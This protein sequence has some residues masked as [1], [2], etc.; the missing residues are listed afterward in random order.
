MKGAKKPVRKTS[1]KIF[2]TLGI[3]NKKVLSEKFLTTIC[4]K[5]KVP[6]KTLPREQIKPYLKCPTKRSPWIFIL[7]NHSPHNNKPGIWVKLL[8]TVIE[9]KIR[10]K[11]N[12]KIS[13]F[14][15]PLSIDH[16]SNQNKGQYGWIP[17]NP[18]QFGCHKKITG[19]KI[20]NTIDNLFLKNLYIQFY[21]KICTQSITWGFAKSNTLAIL[22]AWNG[23]SRDLTIPIGIFGGNKVLAGED[24]TK[25]PTFIS[26]SFE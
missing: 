3:N 11:K 12:P 25:S 20:K 1:A 4:I 13:P 21:F 26:A 5:Y 2:C 23:S 22:F 19:I 7:P 15:D 10:P 9:S 17:K 6:H 24:D 14:I 16:G 8:S 18:S